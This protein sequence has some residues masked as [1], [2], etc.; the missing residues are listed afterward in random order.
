[1]C[2]L[3][4]PHKKLALPRI[5]VHFLVPF[6]NAQYTHSPFILI[7]LAGRYKALSCSSAGRAFT[8]GFTTSH[9]YTLALL[10]VNAKLFLI[11]LMSIKDSNHIEPQLLCFHVHLY[12]PNVSSPFYKI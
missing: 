1:M 5:I 4:S 9:K 8:F 7:C 11:F 12:S 2:A 10:N 6:M 3:F